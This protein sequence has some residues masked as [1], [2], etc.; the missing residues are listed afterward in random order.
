MLRLTDF[1]RVVSEALRQVEGG[2][3]ATDNISIVLMCN[4]ELD[5]PMRPNRIMEITGLSSGGV[6]KVVTRL[7]TAGLVARENQAL[8]DDRRAVSV[9]LTNE[10][11]TVLRDFAHVLDARIAD[12][13]VLLRELN[14]LVE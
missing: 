6:T 3:G 12:S 9:S 11:H 14:R 8:T 5:G 2:A 10:G 4:L 1:G 7:E 13:A